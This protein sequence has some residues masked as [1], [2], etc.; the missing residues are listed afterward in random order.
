M[1]EERHTSEFLRLHCFQKNSIPCSPDVSFIVDDMD[2]H[3]FD[4]A[5][6]N[7][8]TCCSTPILAN[9]ISTSVSATFTDN[10]H[11][12]IATDILASK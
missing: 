4:R 6:I 10:R 8:S 11:H 2:I 7:I 9:Q 12:N 3:N 1:Q 5:M